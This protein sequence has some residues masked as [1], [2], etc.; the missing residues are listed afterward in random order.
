MKICFVAN[1]TSD[2]TQVI[3][4]YFAQQGHE[5]HIIGFDFR[6][7]YDPR[8]E[9]HKLKRVLP[10]LGV[11]SG[12]LSFISYATQTKNLVSELKP[13]ILNGQYITVYGFLASLAKF[14]PL[15]VTAWGTDVLIQPR[16]NP[17]WRLIA[18]YTLRR[19]DLFV[20]LF[21]TEMIK[22]EIGKMVPNE[23]KIASL[24]HGIDTGL[25]VKNRQNKNL[26]Q[27][28][29]IGEND[30]IIINIRGGNPIFDPLTF[31][32]A[33]PL[34]INKCPSAR[35]IITYE[36]DH[37]VH[38]ERLIKK[39]RLDKQVIILD[40]LPNNEIAEHLGEA[41]IY[42]STSLSDGAS[43][44]LFEGMACE[45]APVVTNIPANRAWIKD[46]ENGS[47]FKPG[48]YTEL[49]EKTIY[50]LNDKE[51][52]ALFGRKCR[53]IVKEKAEYKIQMAK[54]EKIYQDLITSYSK[55]S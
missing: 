13:D 29:G 33:I 9:I 24:P 10:Q 6:N 49:A 30:P 51:K 40:F 1:G 47:L 50:L 26:R 52:R 31:I 32:W 55:G 18:K 53:A 37:K 22:D 7:G 38:Y 28:Y 5:V 44:A 17:V 4:N 19:S 21:D 27:R 25:F 12:Y 2:H 35:F 54:T 46:G 11:I 8:I 16:R 20:C 3:A 23:L 48:N 45:L 36:K 39:L 42:V 41:D 14:H 15:V 34:V 43:N